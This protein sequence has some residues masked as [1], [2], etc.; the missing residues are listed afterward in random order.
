MDEYE[1]YIAA[2]VITSSGEIVN[3]TLVVPVNID[4]TI[5]Q[6]RLAIQNELANYAVSLEQS[7]WTPKPGE[8][9][10]E[11]LVQDNVGE[12]QYDIIGFGVANEFVP[13]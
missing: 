4:M 5:E 3:R 6:V 7:E 1:I 12:Y 11:G 10:A 8:G 9:F 13:I 2:E